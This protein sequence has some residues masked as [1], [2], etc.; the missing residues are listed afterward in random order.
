MLSSD[1]FQNLTRCVIF[2]CK[3]IA[4][5]AKNISKKR[6]FLSDDESE[7]AVDLAREPFFSK[8]T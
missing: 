5:M 4:E 8:E 1:N 6:S 2:G 7:S 3:S